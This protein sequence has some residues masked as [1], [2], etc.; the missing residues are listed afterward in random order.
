[1]SHPSCW[2]PSMTNRAGASL[3][4]LRPSPVTRG[5]RLLRAGSGGY[6]AGSGVGLGPGLSADLA[7]ERHGDYDGRAPS[8]DNAAP[9]PPFGLPVLAELPALATVL[10]QLTVAGTALLDAVAGLADLLDSDAVEQTTGVGVEHW[11][12]AVATQTRMDRRL[13]LRACRL[14]RRLPTLATAVRHHRI[15]FAQLR[16]LTIGLRNARKEL[17]T[18]LDE[19][20]AVVLDD[21]DRLD[22]P[23]PDVLVRHMVDALDELDADDL[24]ARERQATTGRFLALQ[25]RLDGT[26]GRLIAECDAAATAL[27]DAA[28]APS[29]AAVDAAGSYGAA[30]LDLL[31]ARLASSGDAGGSE[32]TAVADPTTGGG[33]AAVADPTTGDGLSCAEAESGQPTPWIQQL[34]APQLL[35]RLPFDALLDDRIPADLLTRLTGGRLRMT[36]A[37]ARRLA[38]HAGAQLRTIVIDDT[39]TVLGVGR[40]SRQPPGWLSDAL[41]AMHDT[42]TGPG[43]DRPARGAQLDHAVPWWPTGPQALAGTTDLDN[44]GPLCAATNRAKESAGWQ[45][46]QRRSGTRTWTHPRSGLT[47]T[48]VSGT[49]RPTN[50]PRRRPTRPVPPGD[51][52]AGPDDPVDD[53]R[54]RRN[55]TRDTGRNGNDGCGDDAAPSDLPF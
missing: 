16:G 24:A 35:L 1:M 50:D 44:L 19:L 36:A 8:G 52:R 3:P 7:A 4:G 48:T 54:S 2:V 46:S 30:R 51:N 28:T 43:C 45:V 47:T 13:L 49:W 27:I 23:D 12:A 25:P 21:L 34:P 26:G 18:Q 37:A 41:A 55:R 9:P 15:S 22:R 42:C 5:H 53:D 31:L 14:L 33:T 32:T 29:P 20:L 38:D 17:D 40:A 39:G 6:R 11:L 10:D